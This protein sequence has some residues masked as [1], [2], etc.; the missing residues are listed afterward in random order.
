MRAPVRCAVHASLWQD[1]GFI[2]AGTLDAELCAT[3]S[4]K[5]KQ[6]REVEAMFLTPR[7]PA[8]RR[9]PEHCPPRAMVVNTTLPTPA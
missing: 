2:A 1:V 4:Q 5:K 6:T 3:Q 9:S 7:A 8:Y